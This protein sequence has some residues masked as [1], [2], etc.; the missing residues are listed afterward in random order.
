[1]HRRGHE[2][3]GEKKEKTP[4][5]VPAPDFDPGCSAVSPAVLFG[6]GASLLL[7]HLL[8]SWNA[9]FAQHEPRVDLTPSFIGKIAA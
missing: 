9:A 8:A 7:A 4:F 1:M 3:R 6:Q 5:S 2:A